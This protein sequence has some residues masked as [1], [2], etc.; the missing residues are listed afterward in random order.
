MAERGRVT[1]P[2]FGAIV[3]WMLFRTVVSL[4]VKVNLLMRGVT[5]A[6]W[7]VIVIVVLSA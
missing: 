6:V 3:N 7:P 4:A 5:P 1:E 2:G